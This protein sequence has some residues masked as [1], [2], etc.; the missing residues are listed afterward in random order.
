MIL[1]VSYLLDCLKVS[2]QNPKYSKISRRAWKKKIRD[3]IELEREISWKRN[4]DLNSEVI[5]IFSWVI[6]RGGNRAGQAGSGSS[7]VGLI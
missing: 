3:M 4:R 2:Y 5:F 1:V 7:Q 6:G